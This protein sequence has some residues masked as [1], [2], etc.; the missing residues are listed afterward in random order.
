MTDREFWRR[1][2]R[3]CK[4]LADLAKEKMEGEHESEPIRQG[5]EA[6]QS[7]HARRGGVPVVAG[8]EAVPDA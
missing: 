1:F 6:T 2:Y 4:G 5:M 8:K 7:V 3:H